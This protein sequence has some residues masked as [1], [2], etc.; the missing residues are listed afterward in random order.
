MPPQIPAEHQAEIE[1]LYLALSHGLRSAAAWQ[2][3][4]DAHLAEDIVHD[5]F[6]AAALAWAKLRERS[7]AERE[8]WLR[9]VMRNKIIDH[10]RADPR[11]A[12]SL[13]ETDLGEVAATGQDTAARALDRVEIEALTA[14]L[15][16]MP[17]AQRRVAFLRWHAGW[18]GQEIAQFLGV[19]MSTVRVHLFRARG[20]LAPHVDS[21]DSTTEPGDENPERRPR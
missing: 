21:A 18:S 8:A 10:W 7:A 6:C 3:G 16:R 2:L 12:S 19:T 13:S 11:R 14:A 17:E 1:A 4:P 5:T 9:T 15:S 20:G